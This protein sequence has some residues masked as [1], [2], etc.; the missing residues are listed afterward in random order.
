MHKLSILLVL[1][2][3]FAFSTTNLT[4]ELNKIKLPTNFKIEV[5][6]SEVPEARAMAVTHAG[7]LVVGT[8]QDGDVYV[9]VRDHLKP[10]KVVKILSKLDQ[11]LG[12]AILDKDLYVSSTNK[13]LRIKDID[14]NL[15]NPK[16]EVIYDKFPTSS[17][18]GGRY[19]AFGPD[20]KLYV[21]VGAPCNVCEPEKNQ[22]TATIMRMDPNGKNVETF[23]SGVRNTVGFDWHPQTK[24]L[25]FTDNGRDMM[26]DDIPDDE[27]NFAS[28]S[29]QHFGF[30]YCHAGNVIDPEFGSGHNCKDYVKPAGKLGGH[31][32]ALGMRFYTGSMF[33]ANFKNQIFVAEHGSWNRGKKSGY[34]V[35]QL[36]LEGNKVISETVFAEGWLQGD[37]VWG[38]PADVLVDTDG[39]LLISDD[40]AGA[41][42]RVSYQAK[43][44]K[45][46]D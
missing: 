24:D 18:H 19:I 30:P 27:L 45:R 10:L 32:A 22:A 33:P 12:V 20:K 9:V 35:M 25:W 41:I 43:D 21:G 23:A 46:A 3:A 26:G 28:K 15:E 2:P 40:K 13:I 4:S 44:S 42:Y 14:R 11:P 1:W 29:G 7:N 34:R 38:R 5:F 8:R 31:V 37:S 6:T 36:N 39:A 17:H 16:S